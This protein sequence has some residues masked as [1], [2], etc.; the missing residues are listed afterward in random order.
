MKTSSAVSGIAEVGHFLWPEICLL[1]YIPGDTCM[2]VQGC[3][4]AYCSF[5]IMKRGNSLN[6]H[7]LGNGYVQ[8]GM[9]HRMEFMQKL[10]GMD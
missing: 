10:E 3:L 4:L 5:L 1:R 7:Q 2:H 9:S 6:T 8:Y